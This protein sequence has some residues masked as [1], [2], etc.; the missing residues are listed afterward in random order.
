MSSYKDYRGIVYWG[1]IG[2]MEK[3]METTGVIGIKYG[4]IIRD[5]RVYI[6]GSKGIMEK[7]M[8]TTGIIGAIV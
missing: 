2:I 7:K 6:G 4:F 5:H 8:E 1:H 3:R